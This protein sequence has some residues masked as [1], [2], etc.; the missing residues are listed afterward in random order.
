MSQDTIPIADVSL[1]DDE[2]QA[3]VDVLESGYL[4]QGEQVEQLESSFADSVGAEHAIAVS[5]GTAALHVA[6]LATLEEGSEVLVPAMTHISTASMVS[7]AGCEPVFCDV[8]ERRYTLDVESARER[9]SEEAAAITPV[10]LFGN[11]CDIDAITEF[12]RE[13][14]L[15]VFWDAA[16][17]HGSTY[18]GRDVGGFD[19]VVT[20]SFYPTKNMTTTEG[21]MITTNDADIAQ[22]CRRLRA[23]WQTKKYYH[24]QLGLNYRMTDVQAAIGR[25]Q[26][27]KLPDFVA[28]RRE[29]AGALTAGLETVDEVTTPY[30]P[31]EVEHS[32]HQYTIQ[33]NF[34]ELSCTRETFRS[35]LESHGVGTSVHYPRPL[36]EQ[37][38]FDDEVT[39]PTSERLAERVVSLPVYPTLGAEDIERI[40]EGVEAT[41]EQ[42]R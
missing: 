21:G 28:A 37:P 14:N 26:L 13:H 1:S 36:H 4:V 8:D 40:V 29:N 3:A 20:Y 15:T 41:V 22:R 5:S 30:V 12:A 19:D 25:K 42:Y 18:D 23:H 31:P 10:H 39:L 2:I 9:I 11:V 33:I 6:Y 32:Y 16:Q 17:A 7:F 34:D 38:A 24:P 35:T 27:E